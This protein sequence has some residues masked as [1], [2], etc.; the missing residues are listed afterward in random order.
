MRSSSR[1]SRGLLSRRAVGVALALLLL[2]ASGAAPGVAAPAPR[3]A[4]VTAE[5][6]AD[7][8]RIEQYL[9][10]IHTL[11]GRFQQFSQ[12][13]GTAGGAVYVSRPG[14]M[15]FEYDKPTPILIVADGT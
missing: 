13:G 7:M 11:S 8:Q 1:E 5:D 6:R 3:P 12:D 2:A 9:N 4:A 10:G 14:R 15:R